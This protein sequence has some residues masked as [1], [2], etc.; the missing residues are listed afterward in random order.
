MFP[1]AAYSLLILLFKKSFFHP[2]FN[3]ISL[4]FLQSLT[5]GL[6][7]HVFFFLLLAASMILLI[8]Y[9]IALLCSLYLPC[10]C[11]CVSLLLFSLI[12]NFSSDLCRLTSLTSFLLVPKPASFVCPY[13][14]PSVCLAVF[15]SNIQ[16]SSRSLP[17]C[18]PGPC[19][20]VSQDET[21]GEVSL[22]P[23]GGLPCCLGDALR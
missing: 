15:G 12:V 10:L 14:L 7:D 18:P 22:A 11:F 5:C 19:V 21:V 16:S 20:C 6:P 9:R 1:V 8:I 2:L 23:A 3:F 13:F 17:S 4:N